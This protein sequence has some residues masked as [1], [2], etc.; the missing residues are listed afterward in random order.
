MIKRLRRRIFV[1]FLLLNILCSNGAMAQ[2]CQI[3]K[4]KLFAYSGFSGEWFSKSVSFISY[5]ERLGYAI[6]QNIAVFIPLD[7][8]EALVDQNLARH[9]DFQ[10]KS[11]LGLSIM[12]LLRSGAEIRGTIAGMST[13]GDDEYRY[14][15]TR[16]SIETA[17]S[18]KRSYRTIIGLGVQHMLAYSGCSVMPDVMPFVSI[19]I[20]LR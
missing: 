8:S 20:E 12:H 4:G 5:D 15:A 14:W 17:F 1:C 6:N 11:G 16:L 9:Y 7:V 10:F 18:S 2:N 3:E 13:I 19:G